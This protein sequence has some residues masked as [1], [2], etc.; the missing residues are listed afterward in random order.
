[1]VVIG[2]SWLKGT[3]SNH[4]DQDALDVKLVRGQH[5]NGLHR[6]IGRMQFDV[7]VSLVVGFDRGF[8]IQ[9]RHHG[10]TVPGGLLLPDNHQIAGKNAVVL[11]G[12]S[13]DAQ[14]EGHSAFQHAA[15]NIHLF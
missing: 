3:M 13:L 8:A 12:L 7:G 2:T 10:L 6:R 4:T 1:M 14:G 11:H 5:D 15:G 9:E